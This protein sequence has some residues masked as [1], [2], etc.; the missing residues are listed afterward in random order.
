MC[1][2]YKP[3][4][5]SS[6]YYKI[7]SKKAFLSKL[8]AGKRYDIIHISAHGPPKNEVGIGNGSTWLAKPEEIEVTNHRATLVFANACMANKKRM[9]EAFGGARYFLAPTT[10]VEWINAALFSLVF[11]KRYVVDGNEMQSA[12]E[13]ARK[14]T[15]TSKDYPDYWE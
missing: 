10:E 8:N 13:Y 14:R 7:N 4:K 9:A 15:Q 6:L 11:Y 12:F 3:A 5:G 1:R 2:L